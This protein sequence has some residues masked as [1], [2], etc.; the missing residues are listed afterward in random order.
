MKEEKDTFLEK[1]FGRLGWKWN[2]M[3]DKRKW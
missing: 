2:I 3:E 1:G